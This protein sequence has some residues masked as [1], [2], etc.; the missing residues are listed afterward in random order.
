[1]N[2]HLF[3]CSPSLPDLVPKRSRA[4]GYARRYGYGRAAATIH[5][6]ATDRAANLSICVSGFK[7]MQRIIPPIALDRA[8]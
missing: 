4:T 6:A 3:R 2:F 8:A 1:M 5:E 7:A